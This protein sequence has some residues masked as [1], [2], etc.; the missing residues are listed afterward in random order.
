MSVAMKISIW[1]F[2]GGVLFLSF[3]VFLFVQLNEIR[4][5]ARFLLVQYFNRAGRDELD[6]IEQQ[7]AHKFVSKAV[8]DRTIDFEELD[9][10]FLDYLADQTFLATFSKYLNAELE[11]N[12]GAAR[13]CKNKLAEIE[14]GIQKWAASDLGHRIPQKYFDEELRT[15]WKMQV[16]LFTLPKFFEK[17]AL[18]FLVEL[19]QA[20]SSTP[21]ELLQKA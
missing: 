7:F 5:E 10:I 12:R 15:N 1:S 9:L 17:R 21:H 11:K 13:V 3:C 8:N 19:K 2:G 20:I 18:N 6:R 4:L 14:C 16:L